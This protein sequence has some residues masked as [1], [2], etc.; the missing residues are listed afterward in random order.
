MDN[1]TKSEIEAWEARID[2]MDRVEM[3]RLHRFG[4]VGHPV[5]RSDLPLFARFEARFQELGGMTLEISK[6]IEW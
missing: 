4:S 6:K 5:F 3:A 2:R 1:P